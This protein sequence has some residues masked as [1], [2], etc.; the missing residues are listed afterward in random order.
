[1]NT[2]LAFNVTLALISTVLLYR[3]F[4]CIKLAYKSMLI[5]FVAAF[6]FLLFSSGALVGK[7]LGQKKLMESRISHYLPEIQQVS[8]YD[9]RGIRTVLSDTIYK[10]NWNEKPLV[11][12]YAAPNC[13]YIAKSD[14]L[15]ATAVYRYESK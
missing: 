1:M 9:V 5:A 10:F 4:N 2:L 3:L 11:I 12:P 8:G 13:Y 15:W 6:G 7:F 14:T